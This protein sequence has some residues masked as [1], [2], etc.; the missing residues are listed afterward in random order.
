MPYHKRVLLRYLMSSWSDCNTV[1]IQFYWCPIS[2]QVRIVNMFALLQC[3]ELKYITMLYKL[4]GIQ[5]ITK[6]KYMYCQV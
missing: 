1:A 6:H 5:A 4:C 3:V 2:S